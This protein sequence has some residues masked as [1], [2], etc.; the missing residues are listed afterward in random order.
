[1]TFLIAVIALVLT[2]VFHSNVSARLSAIEAKLKGGEVKPFIPVGVQ[3]ELKDMSH[4]APA[5]QAKLG[6][7]SQQGIPTQSHTPP[8]GGFTAWLKD[9]WLMKLGAAIFIIGFGWFVSY[10]FAN[11][12][13]GPVGRISIGIIA[14][15]IIML[16]GFQRMMKYRTQGAVFMALGAGMMI[17]TIFAGRSIYQFFTPTSSI[18]FDF[19]IIAFISF[20]SFKY[21]MRELAYIAQVL[22]FVTPLLTAG[23]TDEIFLFSYMFGVS[24]ATLFLASITGWRELI[25]SSLIFVGLYSL[26]YLGTGNPNSATLLN[27]AYAFGLLYLVSGMYA[28]VKKGVES[29]NNEITLAVLNGLF[30]FSWIFNVA[31]KEWHAMLFAVWAMIFAISSFMAYRASSKLAPFYAHGSVAVAFI[32][33]ATAAQ[34]NGVTLTIAFIMEVLLLVLSVLVLTKSAQAAITASSL[35]LVPGLMTIASMIKY[36]SSSELFTEDFFVLVL[37]A[38]ALITAGRLIMGVEDKKESPNAKPESVLVIFGTLYIGYILWYFIHILLVGNADMATMT[39]LVVYTICG[40]IAY[41]IGL[42]SKDMA[43]ETYGVILLAFVVVRLV[44]IDV[45]G[46]ALFGRVVTFLA[47]GVLLMSTAFFTKRK[48]QELAAVNIAQ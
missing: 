27:F 36:A 38:L 48:R 23:H 12:W 42:S 46:M 5:Q 29:Y 41:F 4:Y 9:D 24:L 44:F 17:L 21:K 33:A 25:S 16:F 43:R 28:V 39:T 22:A 45:W 15:A 2:F 35:F 47:I 7:L 34:L 19:I 10:A 31:A 40:L 18:L 13:I 3:P 8:S 11:N 32:A 1:M 20:A 6:E 26:P 37:M 14:G 30:L